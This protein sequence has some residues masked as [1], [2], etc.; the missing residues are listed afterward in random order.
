MVSFDMGWQIL[1]VVGIVVGY[2]WDAVE[3]K[4]VALSDRTKNNL[5]VLAVSTFAVFIS[6]NLIINHAS[7]IFGNSVF[8]KNLNTQAGMLFSKWT[9]GPGRLM[10]DFLLFAILYYLVRSYEDEINTVTHKVFQ[11]LGNTPLFVYSCSAVIVF[12][13][14]LLNTPNEFIYNF[15]I[16]GGALLILYTLAL[17]RARLSSALNKTL[18][19]GLSLV[20]LNK[21]SVAES[22]VVDGI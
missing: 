6:V 7:E 2:H 3:A 19:T 15:C 12:P 1:F 11:V 20:R 9:M 10:S 5:K 13:I 8:I 14:L 17:N 4:I 16:V 21:Q 22:G 18:K